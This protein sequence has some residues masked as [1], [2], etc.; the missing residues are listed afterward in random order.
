MQRGVASP[1]SDGDGL[2]NG[3]SGGE[4]CCRISGRFSLLVTTGCVGSYSLPSSTTYLPNGQKKYDARS[5][6]SGV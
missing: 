3:V 1:S 4:A 6:H 2:R 5:Q